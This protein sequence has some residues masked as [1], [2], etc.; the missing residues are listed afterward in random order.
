[1]AAALGENYLRGT[2]WFQNTFPGFNQGLTAGLFTDETGYRSYVN[3]LN[4]STQQYLGRAV[5]SN[6]VVTALGQGRSSQMYANYLQGAAYTQ[7]LAPE[8][9]YEAGAFTA[10]GR[11]SQADLTA[12]GNEKAGI[13]T[14]QGQAIT[15][16]L[17]LANQK[18]QKIFQGT[19]ATPSLT[20]GP[21]GLYSP[22]LQG[23][24]QGRGGTPDIGA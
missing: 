24:K 16:R 17:Q 8:A 14:A 7:T 10:E 19:L 12:Y 9:Q 6:E 23:A 18:M 22:D 11:L 13:D 4:Q 20:L 15:Q 21:Q 2:T 5:T 3:E 1:M